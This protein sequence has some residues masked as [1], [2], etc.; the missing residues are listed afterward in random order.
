MKHR[1]AVDPRS[2]V[3]PRGSAW[4]TRRQGFGLLE[5][6]IVVMIVGI[7]ARIALPAYQNLVL[8]ARAVEALGDINA[9]RLAA[10]TY[11]SRTGQWPADVNRGIVP[12]ELTPYLGEQFSFVRAGYNL[13]WDNWML[14]DGS[15]GKSETNVLLGISVATTNP[16]LGE[17]LVSLVGESAARFTIAE[18]YTFIILED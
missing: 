18:H 6:M 10:F 8:R 14:P 16:A 3:K 4:S 13:D 7:M 9:I 2:R 11:N 1:R 15:P 12:P 5:L 17:A